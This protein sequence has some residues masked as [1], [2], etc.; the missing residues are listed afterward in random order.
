MN[1]SDQ[2]YKENAHRYRHQASLKEYD[3]VWIHF[4]ME[5]FPPRPY[6]KL[7]DQADGPFRVLRRNGENIYQIDLSNDYGVLA[8]FNISN[9]ISYHANELKNSRTN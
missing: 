8:S 4:R 3:V 7:H 5:R 1:K 6:G 2:K 9:L